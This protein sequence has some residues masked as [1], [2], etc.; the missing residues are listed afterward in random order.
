MAK[1]IEQTTDQ[2]KGNRID[3]TIEGMDCP[4]CAKIIEHQ[5]NQIESIVSARVD[6]LQSSLE[7][8]TQ[9]PILI[10]EIKKSVESLGYKIKPLTGENKSN[11]DFGQSLLATHLKLILTIGSGV[12][13][14]TGLLFNLF[15]LPQSIVIPTFSAAIIVGGFFIAKRGFIAVK[16]LSLDI[17]FLMTIAVIGAIIIGEWSEAAVVIFLFSFANLLESRSMAKARSAIQSLME[18]SPATACVIRNGKEEE[19]SLKT[20]HIGETIIVK[21]GS[22]IP[23]DGTIVGGSSSVDQSPITGES[24]PVEKEA[25]DTVYA[26]TINQFGALEINVTKNADD[27]TLSH[28]IK[29]VKE[30]QSKKAKSQSFI[31]KFAKFYTPTVVA[32][33]VLVAFI[34]PL[35]FELTFSEWFYKALVLLV[36]SCPCALVI[37]TP[38]TIVSGLANAARNGILIKGGRFLEHIG[39]AEVI[40]FDK[41]GTLTKGKLEVTNII[42]TNKLSEKEILE[43]AASIECRSEHPLAQAIVQKAIQHSIEL[44]NSYDVTSIAGKGVSARLNGSTYYIGNHRMFEE[45]SL[46]NPEVDKQLELLEK[47]G[48]TTIFVGDDKE[49]LGIIAFSDQI[50]SESRDTIRKFKNLGITKT[51][52]VTGDNHITAKTIAEQISIDEYYAELLPED[53]LETI[54]T[55]QKK[56][57]HTVMVGDGINDAPALAQASIGVA[58]G[59]IGTDAALETADIA[60]MSDNLLKLPYL[61]RL[62]RKGVR[63]IK[64]NIF[65]AISLKFVFLVLAFAGVATLWMAVMADMGASLLVIFNGMRALRLKQE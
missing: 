27:T 29:L 1:I 61:I 62:S 21:P 65:L 9:S 26:G 55:L 39:M 30:A 53:K 43:L 6:F 58:M 35:L 63:I 64:E 52:M 47:E 48:K 50:R 40:V 14:I 17:D 18:L 37:S 4:N 10:S 31:E 57:Q 8:Q 11:V 45:N 24:I 60:L 19:V 59:S 3:F 13:T 23:L 51:V 22:K 42:S 15:D 16:Y 2:K 7:V 54:K 44:T 12:L 33:A 38:V 20:V 49:T 41:T 25:G 46:C 36:I 56:Y 34:P 5:V 28:I 32:I